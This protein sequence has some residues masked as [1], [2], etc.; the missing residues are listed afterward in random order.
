MITEVELKLARK[1]LAAARTD[2]DHDDIFRTF[3]EDVRRAIIAKDFEEIDKAAAEVDA[4][5]VEMGLL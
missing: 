4:I 3:S 2:K 1:R 5:M